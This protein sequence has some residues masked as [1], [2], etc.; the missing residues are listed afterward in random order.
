MA[1]SNYATTVVLSTE[2]K[3]SRQEEEGA[4]SSGRNVTSSQSQSIFL[5]CFHPY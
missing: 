2:V 3:D 1:P 5:S 4:C